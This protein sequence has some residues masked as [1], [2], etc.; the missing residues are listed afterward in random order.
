MPRKNNDNSFHLD[1]NEFIDDDLLKQ[2]P[3]MSRIVTGGVF[4][5]RFKNLDAKKW[6][7]VGD[8]PTGRYNKVESGSLGSKRRFS[9]E[10]F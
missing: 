8:K 2:I 1:A 7:S 10:I 6:I 3:K 9:M 5:Q 4:K